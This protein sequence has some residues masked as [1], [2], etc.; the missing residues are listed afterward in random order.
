MADHIIRIT[1]PASGALPLLNI[2]DTLTINTTADC[3]F[4]CG[5]G[6]SFSP[7]LSSAQLTAGDNGP[8]IARQPA[9]GTYSASPINAQRP[10]TIR[11]LNA[12]SIQINQ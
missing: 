4:T 1:P 5:A 11:A 12:K 7:S 6:D 10:G 9:S 8:Y 2:G 3:T